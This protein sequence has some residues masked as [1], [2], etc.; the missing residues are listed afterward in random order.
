MLFCV[1]LLFVTMAKKNQRKAVKS[2]KKKKA[3]S[4][5]KGS[6]SSNKGM[7]MSM[8]AHQVCSVTNPFCPEA[9]G[10]KWPDGQ[11]TRSATFDVDGAVVDIPTFAS[12]DAAVMFMPGLNAHYT[13]SSGI[14]SGSA[15]YANAF[16][17][18]LAPPA[19]ISRWRLTSW[20]IRLS[21]SLSAMTAA[22]V[23]R[24]RLFSP[25]TGSSL[26]PSSVNSTLADES[27]DVPISRLIN[28]DFHILPKPFGLEARTFRNRADEATTLSSWT[29]PGWQTVLVSIQGGP[30]SGYPV[31]AYVYYHYE[32]LFVD[33]EPANTFATVPPMENPVV[34]EAASGVL[35]RVGNFFEGA[36]ERVDTI[37]KSKAVK[38][39]ASGIAA[40]FGGPQAA[41]TTYAIMD[42][43][44][45]SHRYMGNVD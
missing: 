2:Q 43:S 35:A 4:G 32:V 26:N 12:G 30:A 41:S 37:M 16:A 15:A 18:A 5:K 27:Y 11:F 8:L 10:S 20:G 13:A 21:C 22:G 25:L 7:G 42:G 14:T 33:G 31:Q 1:T 28:K 6:G 23:L 40:R 39:L 29:N 17:T 19:N 36:A 38:Y 34:K 44:S 3:S 45:G 24:V 9:H